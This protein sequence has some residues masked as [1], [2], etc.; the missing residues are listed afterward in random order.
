M[1][2]REGYFGSY[3]VR[4]LSDELSVADAIAE[5]VADG[6]N[7]QVERLHDPPSTSRLLKN[8]AR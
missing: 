5:R 1:I 2:G 4:Q 8:L 6:L 3:L 7:F